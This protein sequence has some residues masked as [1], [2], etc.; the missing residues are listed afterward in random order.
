MTIQDIKHIIDKMPNLPS[1][2]T[3]VVEALNIFENPKSNINQLA[4]IISKDISLT[5]QIL[6]MV[7]SAYYG[8]PSQ[9]TTINKAMA[10]LGFNKVKSLILSVAVKPMMMSHCGKSLWEHSIRCAVGCQMIAKSLG[11]GEG[12][13]AFIMGLLHDIGK[14]VLEIYNKDAVN[15]I[16]RLAGL[17]ANILTAEK[18]IFGFTHTEVGQEL[19]IRWK[20]PLMISTC[21]KYHH[22]PQESENP[23]VAGCVYVAD[24]ITQEQLKYPILDPDISNLLDFDISDPLS[25]REKIFETSQPII[26]ALSK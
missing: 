18:M 17:G 5:T 7:N 15:E 26:N 8:F 25:F 23:S 1:M 4:D 12:D 19:V 10:L 16:N 24:R 2:P 3:V 13:E 9:I 21:V 11:I 6:K 14:T 20:L 22:K